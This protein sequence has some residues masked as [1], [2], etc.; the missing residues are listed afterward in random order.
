MWCLSGALFRANARERCFFYHSLLLL[1]LFS[2]KIPP[3]P[4]CLRKKP[5]LKM[6][7]QLM[8]KIL[9]SSMVWL[10]LYKVFLVQSALYSAVARWGPDHSFGIQRQQ[11]SSAT[12]AITTTAAINSCCCSSG[13]RQMLQRAVPSSPPKQT[14]LRASWDQGLPGQHVPLLPLN[15]CRQAGFPSKCSLLPFWWHRKIKVT[16]KFRGSR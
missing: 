9:L 5:N 15:L 16:M 13:Q 4:W 2:F 3:F 14:V 1:L 11:D 8:I 7:R 6:V 12:T 10:F